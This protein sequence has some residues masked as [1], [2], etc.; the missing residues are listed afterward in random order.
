MCEVAFVSTQCVNDTQIGC[1]QIRC[2]R[3][4]IKK[5]KEKTNNFV[6]LL[7]NCWLNLVIFLLE[8]CVYTLKSHL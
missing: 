5:Q 8:K 3:N 4:K 7:L 6:V 2:M 1:V